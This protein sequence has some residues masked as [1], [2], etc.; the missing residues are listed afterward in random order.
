MFLLLCAECRF[1]TIVVASKSNVS[2]FLYL[3]VV[4]NQ[5]E[6]KVLWQNGM[7]RASLT[8]GARPVLLRRKFKSISSFVCTQQRGVLSNLGVSKVERNNFK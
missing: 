3:D 2:C 1:T 5:D 7:E 6:R 8:L 4:M